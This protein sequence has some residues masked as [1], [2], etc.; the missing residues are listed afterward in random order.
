MEQD[1]SPPQTTTG[2]SPPETGS[3]TQGL[4]LIAPPVLGRQWQA[5]GVGAGVGGG[6]CLPRGGCGPWSGWPAAPAWGDLTSL[7]PGGRARWAERA[8]RLGTPGGSPGSQPPRA[9]P[10]ALPPQRCRPRP[11]CASAEPVSQG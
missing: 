1:P 2:T 4:P 9:A 8:E 6:A 10:A 7:Q 3:C 5:V 11:P